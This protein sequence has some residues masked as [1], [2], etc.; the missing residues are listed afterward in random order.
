MKRC[1]TTVLQ[2]DNSDNSGRDA[3][4]Y[5]SCPASGDDLSPPPSSSLSKQV[6]VAYLP[7]SSPAA[8]DTTLVPVSPSSVVMA[9]KRPA[10]N[11]TTPHA[12]ERK[13]SKLDHPGD[14]L[15][16]PE[17]PTTPSTTGKQNAKHELDVP[18]WH[19]HTDAW[20][21]LQSLNPEYPSQYLTRQTSDG[22]S[23]TAYLFGRWPDCDFIFKQSEISKKHCAIYMERGCN[24]NQESGLSIYLKDLSSNGTFVNGVSVG[25]MNRALLRTGDR[26]QLY[27]RDCFDDEDIRHSF[28]RILLP[29][30][31][32]VTEFHSAY[33][34]GRVLG[35]GSFASVYKAS[36][37][38]ETPEGSQ[39]RF[40]AV[41]AIRKSRCSQKPR[42]LPSVIQEIGI[43]M[44]LE[45]HPCVIK[46]ER[47]FDEPKH[48]YLVLEYVSGGDLFDLV[49]RNGGLCESDTRF[50]FFQL[51]AGI[52]FLHE[53]QIAHRDLKPENVLVVDVEK[54]QVKIT[55]FGLAKTTSTKQ[56]VLDSQCGT[57]NYVAPEILD[58]TGLR[59]YTKSCDLWSLGVILYICLSGMPPFSGKLFEDDE[60]HLTDTVS[61][62]D[63]GNDPT[64]NER[65]DQKWN[66]QL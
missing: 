37:R 40:V 16:E 10:D 65:K 2:H 42:L 61:C 14:A 22:K 1:N 5:Y 47:V 44:S 17:S 4:Q 11:T 52:K 66:I 19:T 39:P 9:T 32:E 23:S 6:T 3:T 53:R 18:D 43:L 41:K 13:Q 15:Y 20:A 63:R 7:G 28:Y 57:P 26:I 8:F 46:I 31:F 35:K 21:F 24:A 30:N 48:I 64:G 59:S 49:A 58:P 45:A 38:H 56:S 29:P 62:W 12:M 27:R 34:V 55:D 33:R 54:L 36:S 50:I 60:G 25:H 51:F